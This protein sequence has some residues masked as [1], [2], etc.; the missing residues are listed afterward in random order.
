MPSYDEKY[1]FL[2]RRVDALK[3]NRTGDERQTD[4]EVF[5]KR[6]LLTIYDLMTSG[7]IDA[8]HYPIS[9]GKEGNVFYVEDEDKEPMALKIFRTSTSTF[10][11]VSVYIEGD[12][13][14]KGTSGNRWKLIYAWVNKEFRNLQRYM[15]AGIPVPEP[16][17]FDKNCLLM[18]YIGDEHGAAPQLREYKMDDPTGMYDEVVSFI[19]DGWQEAHLVHGD[20]SEYNVLVQDDQPILIDCGQAMTSDFF[21]AKELLKRDIH[22]VNRFFRN[23]GA[24]VIDDETIF[25][26]TVNGSPGDD[27]DEAEASDDEYDEEEE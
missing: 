9:T 18:E 23:K 7:Y 20:L 2:E 3:T 15:E 13:R 14:F 17:T 6:T 24:D 21:N 1:A 5:D 16:I 10:K 26:E 4:G 25:E 11:R 19:I 27:D 8:I 12:P 22:N